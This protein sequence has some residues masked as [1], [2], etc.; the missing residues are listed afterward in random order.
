MLGKGSDA[1]ATKDRLDALRESTGLDLKLGIK[2]LNTDML[3]QY[4]DPL[5]PS[6]RITRELKSRFPTAPVLVFDPGTKTLNIAQTVA[7]MKRIE[8]G[9]SAMP[10]VMVNGSL[11]RPLPIGENPDQFVDE[12]PLFPGETLEN[13]ISVKNFI[14]WSKT[15][16]EVR[17][18][19][20]ILLDRSSLKPQDEPQMAELQKTLEH[21]LTALRSVYKTTDLEFREQEAAGTLPK[22][23]V[24]LNGKRP[25]NPFGSNRTT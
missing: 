18:F 21:G 24:K 1:G 17:Q 12:D 3:V 22:L 4:L 23:R 14:D 25:N 7:L 20:R 16:I 15:S 19:C 10:V 11:V 6:D 13:G 9:G 5:N 2:D 8:R